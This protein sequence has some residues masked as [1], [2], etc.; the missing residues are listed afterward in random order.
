MTFT[1]T[2]FIFLF[3]PI[4]L[5]LYYSIRGKARDYLLLLASLLFY[6]FGEPKMV[7]LLI[8]SIA[9][10]YSL[11]LLF[12]YCNTSIKRNLLII[13]LLLWN[14]GLLF[15]Y[16]YLSFF[17]STVNGLFHTSFA[18]GNVALPLGISFF[19]F[20]AISYCLNV[21]WEMTSAQTNPLNLALYISFF[22]QVSMGPITDY[23]DFEPQFGNREL[24]FDNIISGVKR[25]II[26]LFKK[27]VIANGI[28]PMVDAVFISGSSGRS[29]VSA[30]LGIIGYLIQ[31]YYDFSGY[32][33]IAIGIGNLFG[34]RTPENFNYP[35]ASRNVTEYW[36]R[37]HITLGKWLNNYIY[38]PLFRTLQTR[39]KSRTL[40]D[41]IA[42]LA[43][44]LFSG[45]WHGAAWHYVVFGLY[46]FVFIAIEHKVTELKKKRRK[47]LG[48]KKTPATPLE[49]FLS[50]FYFFIVLLFG[51]LLF[52]IEHLSD[53]VPYFSNMFGILG[54]GFF[55]AKAGYYLTE[56]WILLLCG[57]I[58]C[59]PLVPHLKRILSSYAAVE[60]AIPIFSTAMYILLALVSISYAFSDSYQSFIYFQF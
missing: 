30:W 45:F 7:F 22:P 33:D 27:L 60:K 18:V 47:R 38:T 6:T 34:F 37:W 55:D 20:R 52:R 24:E 54:N 21:F 41:F 4:T 32:S 26:G 11:C 15:H 57:L 29:V 43:T 17:T 53:F 14:L 23:R 46:Y 3:L 48:L 31:L 28:G 56:N 25:I 35:Y 19:T 51:Q 9:I 59:F 12:K 10:N 5:I 36:S 49:S 44:W 8:G 16:K 2:L 50:H 58:F 40:C 13:V 39:G 42:L 1:S